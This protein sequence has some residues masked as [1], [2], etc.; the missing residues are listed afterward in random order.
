MPASLLGANSPYPAASDNMP[1]PKLI[2]VETDSPIPQMSGA[3]KSDM[4]SYAPVPYGGKPSFRTGLP[5]HPVLFPTALSNGR[6][7]TV[8]L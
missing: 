4:T 6:N 2:D 8:T 7:P 1:V 5:V 3:R